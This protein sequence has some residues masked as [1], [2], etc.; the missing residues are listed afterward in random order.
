MPSRLPSIFLS[1]ADAFLGRSGKSLK[2]PSTFAVLSSDGLTTDFGSASIAPI[3]FVSSA[4]LVLFQLSLF[5][6]MSFGLSYQCH[7]LLRLN[8]LF[9]EVT[10]SCFQLCIKRQLSAAPRSNCIVLYC[11][12]PEISAV[13][14]AQILPASIFPS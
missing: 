12:L 7:H 5:R 1:P 14:V 8:H 3:L 9:F 10:F 4:F 2:S 13:A 6:P 11:I